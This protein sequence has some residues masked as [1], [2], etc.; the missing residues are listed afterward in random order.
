MLLLVSVVVFAI[1]RLGGLPAGIYLNH[2]M[3]PEQ[4]A[5]IYERYHLND[6]IIRA[7]PGWLGGL[8]RGDL[9]W[10]GVASQP[11]T[12]RPARVK[13][14]VTLELGFLATSSR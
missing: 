12:R 4:V 9:G 11:V 13:L 2:D 6:S 14:P 5:Q 1:S 3:T 7:V 10:S 8:L